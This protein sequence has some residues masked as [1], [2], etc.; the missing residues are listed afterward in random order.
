MCEKAP[1]EDVEIRQLC[2]TIVSG[3]QS[4]ID[5]MKVIMN[6]LKSRPTWADHWTCPLSARSG[7]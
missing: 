4:E 7:R 1:I 5:Q 6:R 3:Q 2:N